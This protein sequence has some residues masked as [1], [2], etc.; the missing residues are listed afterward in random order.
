M[1]VVEVDPLSVSQTAILVRIHMKVHA[2]DQFRIFLNELAE[3]ALGRVLRLLTKKY[4]KHFNPQQRVT[5][6]GPW[7]SG[8]SKFTLRLKSIWL[9]A[10]SKY[11]A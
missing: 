3:K 9:L 11:G 5:I 10:R 6:G 2:E 1:S 7:H 4:R 8:N